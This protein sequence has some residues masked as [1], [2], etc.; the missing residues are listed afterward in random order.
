MAIYNSCNW[1]R[2]CVCVYMWT[3]FVWIV[4]VCRVFTNLHARRPCFLLAIEGL[5]PFWI[6]IRTCVRVYVFVCTC[7]CVYMYMLC[8]NYKLINA[9]Q[10]FFVVFCFVFFSTIQ[11]IKLERFSHFLLRFS[12]FASYLLLLFFFH[13]VLVFVC[14]L[15]LHLTKMN[16]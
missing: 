16:Q 6:C 7:M 8:Y 3:V 1:L 13:F 4:C 5:F 9:V 11:L 14:C 2:T 15:W 12:C 10:K